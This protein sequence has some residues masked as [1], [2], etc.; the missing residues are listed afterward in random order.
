MPGYKRKLDKYRDGVMSEEWTE[1]S[2]VDRMF[3]T[4]TDAVWPMSQD[5]TCACQLEAMMKIFQNQAN[6]NYRS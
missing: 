4:V 1:S 2:L 5:P 6:K 3:G